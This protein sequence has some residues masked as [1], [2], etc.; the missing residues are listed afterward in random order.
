[1]N[2][3]EYIRIVPDFPK[4]G[5]NFYD[6]ASL[7][8]KPQ[9]WDQAIYKLSKIVGSY[10]PDLVLGI[11]SRGFLLAAPVA[12]ELSLPLGMVRKSGKLPGHVLS[13]SYT[14]EYGEDAVEIQADMVPAGARVVVMDDLLATGGTMAATEALVQKAGAYVMANVCLIELEGLGGREKLKAPF[15]SVV[16]RTA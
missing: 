7:M 9:I 11:E 15:E 4:A 6:I 3:G 8:A 10:G 14:L 12:R 13:Q 1:M 16:Q 2:I 5:V